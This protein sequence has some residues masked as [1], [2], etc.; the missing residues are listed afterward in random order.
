MCVVALGGAVSNIRVF[1]PPENASGVLARELHLDHLAKGLP[2]LTARQYHSAER[3][4]SQKDTSLAAQEGNGEASAE[5]GYERSLKGL[6]TLAN[7]TGPT[8]GTGP[9]KSADYLASKLP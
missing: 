9:T 7:D 2:L 8:N 6:S 3:T 4:W 1:G 5:E